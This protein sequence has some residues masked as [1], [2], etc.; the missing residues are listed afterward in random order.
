[1]AKSRA[2][3]P[4]LS[5]LRVTF[6]DNFYIGPGPRRSARGHR[7]DRL[8]RGR[9]QAHGDELQ[10]RLEPGAG[11]Q[12][13]L[14]RAA[15]RDLARRRRAGRGEPHRR[16][17]V[18]AR[19]LPRHAG[20]DAR[21]DRRRCGGG[22]QAA[23]SCPARNNACPRRRGFATTRYSPSRHIGSIVMRLLRR[24]FLGLVVAAGARRLRR[25]GARPPTSMP[26][27]PPTSPRSRP[28]SP[29][30]SRPRPAMT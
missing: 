9:R 14:G 6:S 1:M 13:G 27:S 7:R 16:R 12:R 22:Q 20:G 26:P 18:R 10:A 15:G 23:R 29:P 28:T 8:D 2:P 11:A 4:G 21:G 25:A 24:H 5:H 19:A 30:R 3:A 17:R